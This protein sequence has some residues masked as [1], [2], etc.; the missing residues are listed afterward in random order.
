LDEKENEAK[1]LQDEVKKKEVEAEEKKDETIRKQ[2][3]IK[4]LEEKN[5]EEDVKRDIEDKEK[6]IQNLQNDAELVQEEVKKL[7]EEILDDEFKIKIE[8]KGKELENLQ[9]EAELVLNEIEEIK[10]K[11]LETEVKKQIEDKEKEL[12]KLQEEV[13]KKEDEVKELKVWELEKKKDIEEKKKV[14]KKFEQ[15]I[16]IQTIKHKV[17]EKIKA[18]SQKEEIKEKKPAVLAIDKSLLEKKEEQIIID[19][20]LDQEDIESILKDIDKKILTNEKVEKVLAD[21]KKEKITIERINER[22]ELIEEKIEDDLTFIEEQLENS[23]KRYN[24]AVKSLD[25]KKVASFHKT[26]DETGKIEDL[27]IITLT[28]TPEKTLFDVSIFEEIPKSIVSNVNEI[29]FYDSNYEVIEPDPLIVWNFAAIDSNIDISYGVK[30]IIDT[31]LLKETKTV[32]ITGKIIEKDQIERF[33]LF[34]I[35]F[36]AFMTFIIAYIVIFFHKFTVTRE[37]NRLMMR[38]KEKELVDITL[39]RLTTYIENNV[40]RGID[41]NHIEYYLLKKGWP[42]VFVN[43]AFN[44]IRII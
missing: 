21:L 23:K 1:K 39:R 34:S 44:R 18:A 41:G 5:L 16:I 32:P 40:A 26:K 14:L 43:A 27:T 4:K 19:T 31:E 38:N 10:E 42:K 37:S 9:K 22:L 7:K 33:S 6:V 15:S 13:D 25:I 24:E 17:L 12:K 8:E 20:K 2:D 30:K 11:H 36:P 35:I 3:E 29:I 28:V